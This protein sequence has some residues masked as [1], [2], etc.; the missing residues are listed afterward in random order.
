MWNSSRDGT[1]SRAK[2]ETNRSICS[3]EGAAG[4]CLI[5]ERMDLAFF[6]ISEG[7]VDLLKD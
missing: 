3:G 7:G 4:W 2:V 5:I 6:H 1:W